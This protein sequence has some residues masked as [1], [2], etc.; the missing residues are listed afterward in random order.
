MKDYLLV[1]TSRLRGGERKQITALRTLLKILQSRVASHGI[2]A[3]AIEM[4]RDYTKQL[5]ELEHP[6]TKG[7]ASIT[8]RADL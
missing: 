6:E 1:E 5:Y 7:E 4:R 3:R 2:T 8:N